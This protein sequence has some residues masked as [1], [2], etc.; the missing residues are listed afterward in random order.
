MCIRNSAVRLRRRGLIAV[1]VFCFLSSTADAQFRQIRIGDRDG[2]GWGTGMAPP[3]AMSL[4][5]DAG[6]LCNIDGLRLLQGGDSIPDLDQNGVTSAFL[7]NDNFDNRSPAELLGG[8][9]T[10]SGS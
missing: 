8:A 1:F 7:G 10:G 3:L 4:L 2:F 6:Q 9:V 5:N